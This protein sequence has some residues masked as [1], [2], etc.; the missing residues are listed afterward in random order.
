MGCCEKQAA[1]KQK[2]KLFHI[3][4]LTSSNNMMTWFDVSEIHQGIMEH[5]YPWT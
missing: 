5:D 2:E 4:C 1:G 3:R